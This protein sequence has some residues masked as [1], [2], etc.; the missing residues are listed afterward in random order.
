M[1][2][3]RIRLEQK[4]KEDQRGIK[5]FHKNY[6]ESPVNPNY[7]TTYHQ[8]KGYITEMPDVLVDAIKKYLKD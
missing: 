7:T 3:L 1:D 5:W 4:L 2:D 8:I 6:I